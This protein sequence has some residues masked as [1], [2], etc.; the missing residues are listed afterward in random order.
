VL[1]FAA[2]SFYDSIRVLYCHSNRR[3]ADWKQGNCIT[4]KLPATTLLYRKQSLLKDSQAWNN[5]DKFKRDYSQP[6]LI[7]KSADLKDNFIKTSAKSQ[8]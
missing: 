1:G 6:K 4:G 3:I 2:N 7:I 5:Q 8:D